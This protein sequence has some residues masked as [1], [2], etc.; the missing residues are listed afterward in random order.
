MTSIPR[1]FAGRHVADHILTQTKACTFRDLVETLKKPV[2]LAVTGA[3]YRAMTKPQQADAKKVPYLVACTFSES[4]WTGRK[5]EFA[6]QCNLIFLDI[7]DSPETRETALLFLSSPGTLADRLDGLNFAAYRTASSTPEKPRLRVMVDADSIPPAR[8]ADAVRTIA[9]RLG[10]AHVTSESV[11]PT[12]PMFRPSV[13]SDTPDTEHPMIATSFDG[14]PFSVED[15]RASDLP[16]LVRQGN[17]TTPSATGDLLDTLANS[18]QPMSGIDKAEA[19]KM[20]S[21]LSPACSRA[22]WIQVG[23][24]LHHQFG[25]SGEDIW[26]EW[27]RGSREKFVGEADCHTNW[28]VF[29]DT[30]AGRSPIT[31]RTVAM[32]AKERGWTLIKPLTSYDDSDLGNAQA[33][34]SRLRQ[35]IRFVPQQGFW[36][37]WDG[38]R[39][40]VDRT[41]SRLNQ[42]VD[43][44]VKEWLREAAGIDDHDQKKKASKRGLSL[45]D[46]SERDAAL[47]MMKHQPMIM[48]EGDAVDAEPS[49]LGVPNG[50][51]DLST[52]ELLPNARQHHI[53]KSIAASFDPAATCPKWEAFIERVTRDHEG[54]AAFLQRSVGYSLTG[55]TA[56]HVFWFLHGCG[57][58]GKSVFMET[59][60]ALSGEY[61]RRASDRLF[62]ISRHGGDAPLDELAG[63][64]GVRMLFGSETADGVRL[65]EKLVKDLTGGDTLRGRRL[66]CDG[67]DFTPSAKLWM[68]GN[69]KPEICGTD[70]GI[71]R[72]VLLVPFSAHIS[73][74]EQD[75]HLTIKL[76][77]ELPGILNWALAGLRQYREIGLAPPPCV[78]AATNSYKTDEDA[79]GDF[80]DECVESGE[81]PEFA[82]SK[83]ALYVT[84]AQWAKKSGLR[85]PL[86]S[87]SLSRRLKDRGF[88]EVPSRMWSGYRLRGGLPFDDLPPFSPKLPRSEVLEKVTGKWGSNG[89]MVET[90]SQGEAT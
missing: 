28:K 35:D 52:G 14:R 82:V 11:L 83:N 73:D 47:E 64:P 71:W 88:V 36:L 62:S 9:A 70:H 6:E 75:K 90:E 65:N 49:L 69:H 26:T 2:R 16:A 1:Y 46:R 29:R 23:T 80:L 84:Y 42:M 51:L 85:Y 43:G 48:I 27:S 8:Y 68:F 87:K 72:R 54:L 12:Q 50:L 3:E 7:D 17:A 61:G 81:G 37:V 10:L 4:P 32:R 44:C 79:L 39:W 53:T 5:V 40:R 77:A 33:I 25:D 67:F 86:S 55:L 38:C 76:R 24:A 66:Y 89:Q 13:Y 59:M 18:K 56:E 60:Q 20:L 15:I 74:E 19:V 30:P 57:K 21:Y 41:G 22:E 31:L 78:I 58:N 34:T 45:G 63:L